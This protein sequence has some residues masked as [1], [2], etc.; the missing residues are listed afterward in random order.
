VKRLALFLSFLLWPSIVLAQSALL[1]GGAFTAGHT[2]MY[3]GAGSS[4][5]FVQDSGAAGGG[6][7]GAGL[8]EL[9][10]TARGTG[11]APFVGQG[12]GPLGTNLCDYDAPTTNATGYHY[13]CWS[14]DYTGTN[15]GLVFG[16][17][18][19][20]SNIPFVFTINGSPY[21]FPFSTSGVIGPATTVVNDA[22]CW[23]N[24]VG[25]LLKDCGAFVT[26]GGNNTWSGTNNFTGTFEVSGTTQTFPASGAIVGTSDTQS[27]T[28]KS[29]VASEINSGTLS[30]TV[31]PAFTG[32]VTNSAGSVATTI[33]A[34]AVTNT[35]L[36]QAA[37]NTVK[38]NGTGST[39]N[40]TDF[41]MPSCSSSGNALQWLS[42]TGFQ[43]GSVAGTT[44]G[45]GLTLTSTVFSVSTTAPPY[46]FTA[47]VNMSLSASAAASALTIN[48]LAADSGSA[49]TSSHPVLV[50]F[51]S[52]TLATGTVTWTAITSSQSITIPSGATLGT[53]NSVPFRIWIF[54]EYNGGSPE[55][56]VATC[57]TTT[58]IFGCKSWETNRVTT[59]TISGLATSAG[60]A[61]SA[62]GVS[63]DAVRIIGYCDFAS[64]LSTVGSWASAC[65]TLQPFGPGI[66]KP[67]DRV[68]GPIYVTA[69]TQT[70]VTGTTLTVAPPAVSIT[71]TAAPDLISLTSYGSGVVGAG[72]GEFQIYRAAGGSGA[73][74][75]AIGPLP[76][77]TTTSQ[78]PMPLGGLDAPGSASQ[79]TYEVCIKNSTG[80]DT[81][82]YCSTSGA[83]PACTIQVEEIM[84]ALDKP[85]NDNINPGLY[86]RIG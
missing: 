30:A 73:C 26:V 53:T 37:A 32:D 47:P 80:G 50:P 10:L 71:P 76:P 79:Q 35:K 9:L 77:L 60:T 6:G 74:T 69:A 83:T 22:A 68:Q 40:L 61:Y 82:T 19:G 18:G 2:P 81:V 59:T 48:V 63:N 12:T 52:T 16:A 29:I 66:A 57:S 54:E 27:L 15:G 64:G 8:S 67:G 55:I 86:S 62:A 84:G 49:P 1:Q 42:G 56:A 72:T 38:A 4:Q 13:L 20:A 33:S 7:P 43:C 14:A 39:A 34:N 31:M 58:Q 44:A 70:A 45:W 5:V 28:N 75:T 24:L 85:A 11:T 17:G 3:V 21:S 23:N 78:V 25:T 46:G 65:T 51:R 41:S 36:A